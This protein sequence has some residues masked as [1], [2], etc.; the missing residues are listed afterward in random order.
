MNPLPIQP[1][2]AV[3]IAAFLKRRLPEARDWAREK[4]VPWVAWY[5]RQ[6][7]VLVLTD[8]AGHIRAAALGR[9]VPGAAAA[10]GHG[11][12]H[13]PGAPLLWIDA[14]ATTHPTAL[15]QLLAH[16]PR[17]CPGATAVGGQVFS[18][19]GELRMFPVGFL[20]RYF[21]ERTP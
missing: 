16:L 10:R 1:L 9:Q 5:L 14:I 17:K 21:G 15:A 13:T 11:L 20:Q 7:M 18:R 8:D 4:I 19:K 2:T 12:H 6:E 3:Q